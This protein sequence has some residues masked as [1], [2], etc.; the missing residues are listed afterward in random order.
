MKNVSL[1]LSFRLDQETYIG[2][3]IMFIVRFWLQSFKR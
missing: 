3:A 1:V 2:F